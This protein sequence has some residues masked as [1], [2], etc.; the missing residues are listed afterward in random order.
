MQIRYMEKRIDKAS[1]QAKSRLT[2][3]Q[4]QLI[5]KLKKPEERSNVDIAKAIQRLHP[6]IANSSVASILADFRYRGEP[7]TVAAHLGVDK[8]WLENREGQHKY[9]TE[10]LAITK[11][12]HA[13]IEKVI[14]VANEA[15]DE[16]YLG[17]AS[18]LVSILAKM[19]NIKL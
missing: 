19:D 16:I 2:E 18:K 9:E 7:H 1:G 4:H 11:K 5:S 8:A 17:D 15:T 10:K 6:T 12:Y 3:E 14:E 13:A